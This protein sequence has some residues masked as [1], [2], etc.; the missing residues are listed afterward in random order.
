[1]DNDAPSYF[2]METFKKQI[3]YSITLLFKCFPE[4]ATLR[5]AYDFSLND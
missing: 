5:E 2:S 4:K 1:M 3:S